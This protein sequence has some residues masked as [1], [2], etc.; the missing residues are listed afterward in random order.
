MTGNESRS[1]VT[2]QSN[3]PEMERERN[4]P[5]PWLMHCLRQKNQGIADRSPGNDPGTG[6][7][8]SDINSNPSD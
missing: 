5:L 2:N 6:A 8:V 1:G 7:V 4:D 3:V